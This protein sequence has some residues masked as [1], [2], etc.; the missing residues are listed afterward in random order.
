M[1]GCY[2]GLRK[3]GGGASWPLEAETRGHCP[4]AIDDDRAWCGHG[5]AQ[6][7]TALIAKASYEALMK[8]RVL[9]GGF[10]AFMRGPLNGPP[11]CATLTLCISVTHGACPVHARVYMARRHYCM[12]GQLKPESKLLKYW[13]S[14][15]LCHHGRNAAVYV[16]QAHHTHRPQELGPSEW[17][18]RV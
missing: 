6:G 7:I 15:Q 8:S 11:L 13:W 17:H 5:R 16:T 4:I 12:P 14:L 3:S 10:H 2:G 1:S 9:T 18:V